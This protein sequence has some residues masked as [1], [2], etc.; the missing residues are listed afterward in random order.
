MP[1][2][3]GGTS[4]P[5]SQF[6][7]VWRD[8]CYAG[9]AGLPWQRQEAVAAQEPVLGGRRQLGCLPPPRCP[10]FLPHPTPHPGTA[11]RMRLPT[12]PPWQR[13]SRPCTA[14]SRATSPP[15]AHSRQRWRRP[16][17]R[18]ACTSPSSSM[19]SDMTATTRCR[20]CPRPPSQTPSSSGRWVQGR[21]PAAGGCRWSVRGGCWSA[22]RPLCILGGGG[23]AGVHPHVHRGDV[24]VHRMCVVLGDGW[25][26]LLLPLASASAR[27]LSPH[28]RP[29][30]RSCSALNCLPGLPPAPLGGG[31]AAAATSAPGPPAAPP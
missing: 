15:R 29:A 25:I 30:S 22:P 23:R 11:C 1:A 10:T 19:S 3:A 9:A 17:P 24:P 27:Q 26:L 12:M 7:T 4:P 21:A 8:G 20:T 2:G 6:D 14:R 31:A 5:A 16:S 28:G 13:Q 18:E